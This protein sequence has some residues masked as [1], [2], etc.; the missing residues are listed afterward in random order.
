MKFTSPTNILRFVKA[1]FLKKRPF[2]LN[3]S[4]TFKC[5]LKCDMC[6]VIKL[7]EKEMGL[8]YICK[9]LEDARKEGFFIYNV[10]GGEPLLVKDLPLI[11]KYAK[12]LGFLTSINTNGTLLK[13]R[14]Y[15]L[16]DCVDFISV[17]IDGSE[18]THD[19]IRGRGSYE[20][21]IEGIKEAKKNGIKIRVIYT[22]CDNNKEDLD[23]SSK[24]F[25]DMGVLFSVNPVHVGHKS[26]IEFPIKFKKCRFHNV[27]LWITPNGSIRTCMNEYVWDLKE[28]YIKEFM[29]SKRFKNLLK[30]V[31]R[32][33]KNC[34]LLCNS[35]VSLLYELNIKKIL[36]V[37]KNG[38]V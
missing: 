2:V 13:Q 10:T 22:M 12:S 23:N 30:K 32:C 1:R 33:D 3:H 27:F 18:K 17:S 38:F 8:D 14:I 31:D 37:L 9:I 26:G 36:Y 28:L 24:L 29:D 5:N 35:E 19:K 7:K 34:N 15:E 11:L 4:I 6:N 21:S 25:D 20:K 16:S